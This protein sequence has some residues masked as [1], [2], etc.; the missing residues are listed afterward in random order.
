VVRITVKLQTPDHLETVI[1]TK[2]PGI[3]WSEIWSTHVIVC[4]FLQKSGNL[5]VGT[6]YGPELRGPGFGVSL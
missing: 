6:F 3:F 1:L 5:L 4:K 2:T